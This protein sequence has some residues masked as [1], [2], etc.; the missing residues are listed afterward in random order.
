MTLWKVHIFAWYSGEREKMWSEL[1]NETVSS[2]EWGREIYWKSSREKEESE[3][4]N[5]TKV[6][7]IK[8][9]YDMTCTDFISTFFKAVIYRKINQNNI[10]VDESKHLLVTWIYIIKL[11]IQFDCVT[12]HRIESPTNHHCLKF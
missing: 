9:M 1:E 12:L 3:K 6:I 5:S 4:C 2:L 7:L 10:T 11:L 8:F